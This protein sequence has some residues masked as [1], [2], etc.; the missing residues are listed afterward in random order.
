MQSKDMINAGGLGLRKCH[1][2][3]PGNHDDCCCSNFER[4]SSKVHIKFQ[5][6]NSKMQEF[7]QHEREIYEDQT[8]Q[9]GRMGKKESQARK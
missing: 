6:H 2:L 5:D 9:S 8:F 4:Q 7:I 3:N 1:S